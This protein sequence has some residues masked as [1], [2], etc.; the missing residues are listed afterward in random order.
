ML[1]HALFGLA[2][3][4]KKPKIRSYLAIFWP[5]CRADSQISLRV[6]NN[7]RLLDPFVS[8]LIAKCIRIWLFR[9]KHHSHYLPPHQLRVV[10]SLLYGDFETDAW[11]DIRVKAFV[12]S[13]HFNKLNKGEVL[14][15]Y[16]NGGTLPKVAL[17]SEPLHLIR[18]I[19]RVLHCGF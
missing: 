14:K 3:T 7:K 8:S 6:Q 16:L 13:L 2:S 5:L 10:F 15:Y 12:Q 17:I 1:H 9:E 11:R 19:S 4:E 18:L